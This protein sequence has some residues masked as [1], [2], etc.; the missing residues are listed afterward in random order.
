[1]LVAFDV[2]ITKH[3]SQNICN[4]QV[5]FLSS[6]L[7]YNILQSSFPIPHYYYLTLIGESTFFKVFPKC[8]TIELS[9]K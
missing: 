7:V 2:A 9:I 1:M 4:L 3:N 6:L 5:Q 8:F